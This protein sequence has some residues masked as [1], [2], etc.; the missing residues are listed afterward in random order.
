M[1]NSNSDLYVFGAGSFG[2]EVATLLSQYGITV[3]GILD[4]VKTGTVGPWKIQHPKEADP[5]LPVALGVCNL[6]ADL[7]LIESDLMNYGFTEFYTPVHLFS[8]FESHGLEK[9]HYWLTTNSS[10]YNKSRK[11][12]GNFS[13]ILIDDESKSLL[14]SLIS[15]RTK[16]EIGFLPDVYPVSHQYLPRDIKVVPSPMHLVDCGAYVGEFLDYADERNFSI[17]SYYAFEPDPTNYEKLKSRMQNLPLN[18]PGVS[19][20]LGVAEKAKQV[21]FSAD[22]NLGA[23]IS[24]N[25]D[26]VIQVTSLDSALINIPINYIKMDIEGAE[27]DALR[28]S[29]ELLK[30]HK[31]SL[32]ISAY[33]KPEDLWEIGLW[34]DGL[35]LG[36]KFALRQYGH[37]CFDTVLY[38][39]VRN[40]E[41]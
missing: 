40:E 34:L 24:E 20:P 10:L 7:K 6:A 38:A 19:F 23:A 9:D 18:V 14:E 12:I 1:L 41:Q 25:G 13:K 15:Y 11:E 36:Y 22:G 37:Q 39:F 5:N 8:F 30:R 27:M 2:I 28:G 29:L 17:G 3:Q 26:T 21:R 4:N 16:G 32:A 35:D 31:P 33:H